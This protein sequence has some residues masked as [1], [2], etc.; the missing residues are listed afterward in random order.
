MVFPANMGPRITWISPDIDRDSIGSETWASLLGGT[1]RRS[2]GVER[3]RIGGEKGEE[4]GKGVGERMARRRKVERRVD[5]YDFDGGAVSNL[6]KQ[7]QNKKRREEYDV[8][9]IICILSF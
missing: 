4:K 8:L 1:I 5:E 7:K 3:R 9:F 6:A 2:I